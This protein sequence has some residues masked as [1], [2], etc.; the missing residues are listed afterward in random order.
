[1]TLR[2]FLLKR[3]AYTAVLIGFVV[4]F[5]FII[6]EAMP[7]EVGAL[8]ACLGQPRVPTVVCQKLMEQF[9]YNQTIWVRFYDYV[10]AML[11]FN[12]GV[13][14][15]NGQDVASQVVSSGRLGN[16]L[17][18]LGT[19][20]IMAIIIG[21]VSGIFVSRKRGSLLDNFSV[22]SSLTAFSLPTFFTGILLIFIFAVSLNWFPAGGTY[23]S[24]WDSIGLPPLGQQFLVRL[25]Y[26]FLPA[27]TLTLFS[28]GG[29][30]L[31]TRATMMEALSEDY[32]LT[33]RAKGLAER[34][35]LFKHAF[36][37][38]SLPLITNVAL[39]FG[40][41]LSGAIITETIFNWNGLGKWLFDS[42]SFKDFPVMQAMFFM[43]A[44][45]VIAANF[46]SDIIYGVVD[47]RIKYE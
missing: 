23:P 16:T 21:T 2:S 32:V 1:M 18:L 12:F 22:T 7:G 40:F 20:T 19:S 42:I 39:S 38:A 34:A 5:N 24:R 10:K 4:V 15:A 3:L 43:I 31:L 9:G 17:L 37:N 45:S 28:Y 29:F 27:L 46:I 41:I 14:F 11:T 44:L 36:K 8:Y 6:F 35:V 25:Q 33:A 26:L 30:L 13:S 47:P